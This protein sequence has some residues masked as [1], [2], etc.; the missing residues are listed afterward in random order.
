MARYLRFD[1]DL[2]GINGLIP[3]TQGDDWLLTC[4]VVDLVGGTE[5]DQD[6]TGSAVSGFFPAA[7][8]GYLQGTAVIT[9]SACGAITLG[10]PQTA[11]SGA[12]ASVVPQ[13]PYV[14]LNGPSGLETIYPYDQPLAVSAR[15]MVTY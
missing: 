8:G 10:L 15:G 14:T 7:S 11:S 5:L 13:V 1:R 4:R 12:M 6:I 2:Y 9:D 3:L